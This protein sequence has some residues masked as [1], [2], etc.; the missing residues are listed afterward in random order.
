MQDPDPR[1][2]ATGTPAQQNAMKD[3]TGQR[4]SLDR[5]EKRRQEAGGG[6]L[7]YGDVSGFLDK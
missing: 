3:A 4:S 5:L 6:P 1:K 2:D 7:H